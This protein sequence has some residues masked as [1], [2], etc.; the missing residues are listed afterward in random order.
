M[1][2]NELI[3]LLNSKTI[4]L[5][6]TLFSSTEAEYRRAHNTLFALAKSKAFIGISFSRVL[7]SSESSS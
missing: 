2:A 7:R 4:K 3:I 6:S 1:H 5:F